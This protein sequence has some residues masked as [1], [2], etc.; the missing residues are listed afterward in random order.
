[1]KIR[2]G[3]VS[4]SSSSSFIIG[5]ANLEEAKEI[6]KEVKKYSF[7]LDSTKIHNDYYSHGNY[8][9]TPTG[10]EIDVEVLSDGRYKLTIESFTYSTVSCIAKDGDTIIALYETQG[11]DSDF[12]NEDI[13]QYD[14]DNVC[15]SDFYPEVIKAYDFINDSKGETNYGAGRNG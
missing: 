10:V 4:N 9:I 15:I 11:D 13:G 8:I 14:Y 3:F 1:M 7:V 12:W 2:N 5:V 6:T